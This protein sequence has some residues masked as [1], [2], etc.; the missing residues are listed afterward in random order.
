MLDNTATIFAQNPD[1]GSISSVKVNRKMVSFTLWGGGV[2]AGA[3]NTEQLKHV[4]F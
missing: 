4:V 2:S 1:S 3:T